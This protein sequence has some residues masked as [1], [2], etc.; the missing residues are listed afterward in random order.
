MHAI[1]LRVLLPPQPDPLLASE[2]VEV[3]SQT[4]LRGLLADHRKALDRLNDAWSTFQENLNLVRIRREE[5]GGQQRLLL[6]RMTCVD[7]LPNE[8]LASIFA[9]VV[10][11]RE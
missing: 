4:A 11:A 8:L 7:L 3:L 10:E 5:Y 6:D 1:T 9:Y 2:D